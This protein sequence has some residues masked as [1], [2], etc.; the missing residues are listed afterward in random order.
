MQPT[1][2]SRQLETLL[3]EWVAKGW[4]DEA[5][6]QAL[7]QDAT[8]R[9]QARWNLPG[10]I[11]TLGSILVFVGAILFVAANW[12]AMDRTTKLA[13]LFSGMF[14][15]FAGAHY[16]RQRHASNIGSAL[17]MLGTLFFGCNIMLIAQ[18]YH[19]AA[20][21]PAGA[22]TWA[23]G[24]LAVAALWPSQLVAGLGFVLA[25]IWNYFVVTQEGNWFFDLWHN[26]P[27]YSYLLLWGAFT[28]LAT[29]KRWNGLAHLAGLSLLIWCLETALIIEDDLIGRFGGLLCMVVIVAFTWLAQSKPLQHLARTTSSYAWVLF[30]FWLLLMSTA[31][32]FKQAVRVSRDEAT[33]GNFTLGL[34][35]SAG[36]L[37]LGLYGLVMRRAPLLGGAMVMAALVPLCSYLPNIGLINSNDYYAMAYGTAHLCAILLSIGTVAAAIAT[38]VWG[39]QNNEKFFIN[40]GLVLFASKVLVL[41]FDTFHDKINQAQFFLVGGVLVIALSIILERQRRRLTAPSTA[42]HE[43]AAA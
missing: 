43:G 38:V 37:L 6:Q 35:V 22:L 26:S 25:G 2:F 23:L 32:I 16:A 7:L 31:D 20:N 24:G 30:G 42:H 21:P 27:H 17:A 18:I 13:L 19:L 39:S 9:T 1:R 3:P 10:I 14:A 29:Y 41:Y 40:T 36:M 34:A 15:S 11:A 12:E 4:V 33:G 5:H 28:A 8:L